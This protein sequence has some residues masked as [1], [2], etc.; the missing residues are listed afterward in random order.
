VVSF[1]EMFVQM[2]NRRGNDFSKEKAQEQ[3]NRMDG[4]KDGVLSADEL[5]N[6]RQ[7]QGRK[8]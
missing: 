8:I 1:D 7:N 4:N 5:A 2:K 3:F 6:T